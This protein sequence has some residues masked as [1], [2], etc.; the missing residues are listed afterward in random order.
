[1]LCSF[2]TS[3]SLVFAFL[4]F[5]LCMH[6]CL[7]A[8]YRTAA[9]I[10]KMCR[11]K[12]LRATFLVLQCNYKFSNLA[13]TYWHV[14]SRFLHVALV[15]V[16]VLLRRRWCW[17]C[18]SLCWC[19]WLCWGGRSTGVV[20]ACAAGGAA[21]VGHGAGGGP[22]GACCWWWCWSWCWCWWFCWCWLVLV[23]VVVALLAGWISVPRSH[24]V[25]LPR[26]HP[27][28]IAIEVGF[29]STVLVSVPRLHCKTLLSMKA[30]L[31][32][33]PTMQIGLVQWIWKFEE[34]WVDSGM[35]DQSGGSHI[36]RMIKRWCMTSCDKQLLRLVA[37]AVTERSAVPN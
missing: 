16:V 9:S 19:W 25:R 21:A 1:M 17:L 20:G 23:G 11:Y 3:N 29:H 4:Q 14:Q 12:N 6:V 32:L 31:F 18:W 37:C 35:C 34:F 27:D 7:C 2:S 10:S 33:C 36:I 15:L 5:C 30:L 8:V 13:H 28:I 22:G 26:S 24:L